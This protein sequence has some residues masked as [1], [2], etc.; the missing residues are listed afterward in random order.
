M[1]NEI[2]FLGFV[3]FS[4]PVQ[5]SRHFCPGDLKPNRVMQHSNLMCSPLLWAAMRC[6]RPLYGAQAL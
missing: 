5:C 2:L 3:L 1:F 6:Y 4:S